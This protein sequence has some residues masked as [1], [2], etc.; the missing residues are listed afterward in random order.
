MEFGLCFISASSKRGRDCPARSQI[1]VRTLRRHQRDGDDDSKEHSDNEVADDWTGLW[2]EA[3][4]WWL[5]RLRERDACEQQWSSENGKR[6]DD[7]HRRRI[8]TQRS[9]CA[10]SVL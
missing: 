7:A 9:L 10:S 5:L 2:R 8:R 4:L 6:A 1:Q 3:G